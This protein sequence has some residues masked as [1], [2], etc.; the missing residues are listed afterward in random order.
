[1]DIMDKSPRSIALHILNRIDRDNAFAEPLLDSFLS[2][3]YLDNIHDQ[4][5][6]TQL[7]YGTLRMRNHLDWI[8]HHFYRGRPAS[9][10]GMV[11]NILRTA[12]YQI[13][14]MDRIPHFAAVNEAVTLVGKY[15]PGREGL[16]N[17]ILRNAIRKMNEIAY[18]DITTEPALHISVV[19]S[20]P[21]WMVE[22]W[23][24]HLGTEETHA[25]CSGNNGVPPRALRVNA[26]KTTRDEALRHLRDEGYAADPAHYFRDGILLTGPSGPFKTM[27][28]FRAGHIQVQD[29]ASQL[30]SCL[31]DPKQG[32]TIADLC[33]G[34]GI[35]ATHLAEM[36]HNTGKIVACDIS[37]KKTGILRELCRR[38]GTTNIEPIVGDAATDLGAQ[39]HETFDR[40]LVDA[41]CSGTGTLRRNP[42][43]KWRLREADIKKCSLLQK[44]ILH[45]SARYPKKGGALV[46]STCSLEREENEDVVRE[47]LRTHHDYVLSDLP[48]A[49]DGT[50][51]TGEGFF[52]TFPH[53]H[54][55]D[56]FFGAILKRQ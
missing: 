2:R 38:L 36:M 52:R 41:P 45:S 44:N 21:L 13:L 51:V 20:H 25:L 28:L 55:T 54:G 34:S 27:G 4:R 15:F 56:G 6:L 33:C 23:I 40:V 14:F 22:R 3:G 26:L 10:D 18:P 37:Q 47:F 9:M 1:M 8:I 12:L 42:E 30:I 11:K 53:H 50:M 17:G 48:S 39:Y 35:K 43:I 7:V 24:G 29:E 5:L 19:H 32:D 49:I 31:V 46:Y 16:V